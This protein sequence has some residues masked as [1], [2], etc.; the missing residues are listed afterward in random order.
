[1]LAKRRQSV[2]LAEIRRSGS[3]RVGD[4]SLRFGVS[5]MTIRRDLSDLARQGLVEKVHG[6]ALLSDAVSRIEP[7]FEAKTEW[8]PEAKDEIARAAAALVRPGTAIAL[9]AGT[10][11]HALARHLLRVQRLTV[12]TNS[13]RVADVFEEARRPGRTGPVVVLTGG[14]RTPSDALVGPIAALALHDLHVDQVF[15]GCHGIDPDAGLTTPNLAESETNRALMECAS[16]VIV[17]ADHSKWGMVS[18]SSY[19]PLSAVDTLVTDEAMPAVT[20]D[21]AAGTVGQLV[22]ATVPAE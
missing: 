18:L 15:M 6:G 14:V 12:V 13:V 20:R 2:I 8:D 7:G 9:S 16:Q 1:M 5:D 21:A 17:L 10:T 22:V 3:V 4:L 11:T 19:A